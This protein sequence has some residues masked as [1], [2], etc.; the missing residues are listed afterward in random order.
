MASPSCRASCGALVADPVL[1]ALTAACSVTRPATDADAV[2]GGPPL[3]PAPPASVDEASTL[4]RAAAEH[5][6][7]VVPR[8]SGSRL[9]WGAP[10]R[11][12]DLVVDTQRLDQVIE[13]AAGDLV[14]R[15]QAGAGL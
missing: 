11:R 6:L 5:D 12:C 9:G 4:L 2:A 1:A 7:A 14:V 13:H 3:F 15:V 10:P 8:G